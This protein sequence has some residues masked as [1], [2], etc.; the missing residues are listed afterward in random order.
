VSRVRAPSGAVATAFAIAVVT[1]ATIAS[2]QPIRPLDAPEQQALVERRIVN[3]RLDPRAGAVPGECDA[4]SASDVSIVFGEFRLVANVVAVERVPRPERHWLL[5]DVSES[6]EDRRQAALKSALQYVQNVMSPGEDVAALVAVDEDPILID[7]PT[8]DLHE[9]QAK[10]DGVAAGGWSALRD[11]LDTVL[12]QVQGD[13]HEHVIL[14]WTDG[15]DQASTMRPD[16]LLQTLSRTPNAT[17]FPICLLPNGSRF[18]PPPLTGATFTEVA[19]RSGG[20]VFVSS[21]PRWLERVRGWLGRRFTVSYIAPAGEPADSRPSITVPGK[22]CTL[23]MLPDPFGAPDPISGQASPPPGAWMKLHAKMREDDEPACATPRGGASWAWPLSVNATT[24]SGCVFDVVRTTGPVVRDRDGVPD[25]TFQSPRF[26]A[27][28][29]RIAVPALVDL[30]TDAVGAILPLL[31]DQPATAGATSP[32]FMDGSAFLAQRAQ[33]AAGLFA[34]RADFHQFAQARLARIA[35]DE[36][37]AL[38][39]SFARDFPKLSP[40]EI[41]LVARSSRAGARSLASAARPTDADLARVLAAWIDDVSAVDLFRAME[42]HF[43]D[44]SIADGPEGD[45]DALWN[46][47]LARFAMPSRVR[48]ETPLALVHDPA[49]DVIGFVRV[50]LPRPEGFR[51]K[52]RRYPK[53][54]DP[55]SARLVRRPLA[56]GLFESVADDPAVRAALSTGGYR[57]VSIDYKAL[58]LPFHHDPGRP[59]E[60]ARVTVV[61]VGRDG[62]RAVFEGNVRGQAHG[63]VV[64]DR[65]VSTVTGDAALDGIV[66]GVRATLRRR[67]RPTSGLCCGRRRGSSRGTAA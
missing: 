62:A 5:V 47:A 9:L 4:L 32:S 41:A 13:R 51:T 67:S 58:S 49:Q 27:R 54:G 12:R 6:A 16:D 44:A 45:V 37:A 3:V 65:V 7:G 21:D 33:I 39:K 34:D 35:D 25:Y 48:I 66:N 40:D 59:F 11:G 15:E 52:D 17:V 55:L 46:A 38:A 14:Y 61:L 56:V 20:E 60:E 18:P 42:R 2:D 29:I 30:P 24:L 19:R 36:L 31:R 50:V 22:R 53:L 26:A 43:I 23:T 28:G 64:V 10:I 63:P 57:A 8:S 1:C